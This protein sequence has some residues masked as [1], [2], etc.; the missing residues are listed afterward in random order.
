M[1]CGLEVKREPRS[2]LDIASSP[3]PWYASE[4]DT[5]LYFG[6]PYYVLDIVRHVHRYY[7]MFVST[8][9]HKEYGNSLRTEQSGRRVI[10]GEKKNE[11]GAYFIRLRHNLL[12]VK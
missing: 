6:S 9:K 1:L 12:I 5:N 11:E 7:F 4:H 3:P 2:T 10:S 8:H